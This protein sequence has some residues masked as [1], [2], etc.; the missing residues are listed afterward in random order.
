MRGTIAHPGGIEVKAKRVVT[1]R[2]SDVFAVND[3][4]VCAAI[5]FIRREQG[6]EISVSD[7][8]EEVSVSRRSLEK[9]FRRVLGRTVLEEIHRARL[10]NAKKLLLE[11]NHPICTVAA[12]TGFRTSDYFVRFFHHRVGMTPRDFRSASTM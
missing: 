6:R 12:L 2:S 3:A 5:K 11:T 8:A 7:V 4:D 10:E 1:R 9:Q